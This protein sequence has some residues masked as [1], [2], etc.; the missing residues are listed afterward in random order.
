MRK[1]TRTVLCSVAIVVGCLVISAALPAE[2]QIIYYGVQVLPGTVLVAPPLIADQYGALYAVGTPAY[3]EAYYLIFHHP[4]L[5]QWRYVPSYGWRG[6][7]P[8]YPG[9]VAVMPRHHSHPSH[10]DYRFPPPYRLPHR[11]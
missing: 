3:I 8:G 6:L 1:L 5:Q 9:F 4:F 11:R 7:G 10:R 2:A